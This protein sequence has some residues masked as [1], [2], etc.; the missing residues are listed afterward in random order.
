MRKIKV[1]VLSVRQ[2]QH[3]FTKNAKVSPNLTV[4]HKV[5]KWITNGIKNYIKARY[6]MHLKL[7]C[8]PA[9]SNAY[10]ILK[11]NIG[12]FNSILKKAILESKISYYNM[13]F[14]KYKYDIKNTWKTISEVLSKAKRTK[15][16]IEEIIVNGNSVKCE[17][18]TANEFKKNSH[19]HWP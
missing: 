7:A 13:M 18:N 10:P 5:N 2:L 1:V 4:T 16:N 11:H 14:E 17:Q 15:N 6:K 9:S 12:V 19:K 3:G 8:T